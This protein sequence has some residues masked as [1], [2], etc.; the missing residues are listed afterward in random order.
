MQTSNCLL[1]V[2]PETMK[3]IIHAWDLAFTNVMVN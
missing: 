2:S 3:N 1:F